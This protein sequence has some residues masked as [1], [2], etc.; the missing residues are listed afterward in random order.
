MGQL[1]GRIG[2]AKASPDKGKMRMV[3]A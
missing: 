2:S 1:A 3:N